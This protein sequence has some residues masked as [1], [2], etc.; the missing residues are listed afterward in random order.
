MLIVAL[1]ALSGC[2]DTKDEGADG[3]R[4]TDTA[5][6]EP[7]EGQHPPGWEAATVH[8]AAAKLKEQVCTDCHGEDLTG[9]PGAVSCDTCHEAGWRTD[10]TYCHGGV[11][12]ATGAPP[13]GIRDETAAAETRYPPHSTHVEA[14]ALKSA[15]DCVQCHVKPTDILST[16]HVFLGDDTP[17]VADLSFVAGLSSAATWDGNGSCSNL[18]CHG[19]GQGNNGRVEATADVGCGDCHAVTNTDGG[20][21]V[22]MGGRH[23]P[24]LEAGLLCAE[25]HG[26]VVNDAGAI[27]D[28]ARHVD[29]EIDVRLV[30]G[31]TRSG[32]NCTGMCHNEVHEVRIWVEPGR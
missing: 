26:D 21:W 22:G 1:L 30:S 28:V 32:N 16:G 19:N 13:E 2:G 31:M 8:G 24:H 17:A 11:D 4:D 20:G 18:Y 3:G 5:E 14:T 27:V 6:A 9:G 15:Y 7:D 23:Q 12:N 25:C 29:G 10:C